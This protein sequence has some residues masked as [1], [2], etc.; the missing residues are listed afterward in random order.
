MQ[1]TF[2]REKHI[3]YIS[4]PFYLL[5]FLT[6]TVRPG[7]YTSVRVSTFINIY[8]FLISAL[9]RH[10]CRLWYITSC[11][12]TL[13]PSHSLKTFKA[14]NN[15]YKSYNRTYN[16][17]YQ[18][19]AFIEIA[20]LNQS[21]RFCFFLHHVRSYRLF[22]FHPTYQLVDTLITFRFVLLGAVFSLFL[23]VVLV[24]DCD[25]DV[26]CFKLKKRN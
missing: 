10:H 14:M 7:N 24:T 5:V 13:L 3:V 25:N 19:L 20:E 23:T 12:T 11:A 22:P 4:S 9:R 26:L 2:F 1:I 8:L 16:F 17:S 18:F 15:L 21:E 6:Q